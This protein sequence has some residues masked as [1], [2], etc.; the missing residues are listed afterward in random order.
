MKTIRMTAQIYN[1]RIGRDGGGKITLDFG[2]DSLPAIK[3][4]MGL[5]DANLAIAIVPYRETPKAAVGPFGEIPMDEEGEDQLPPEWH[6][7]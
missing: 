4:L 6:E 1:T 5:G 3:E 2:A 7:P